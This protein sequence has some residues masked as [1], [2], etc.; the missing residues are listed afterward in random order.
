MNR[1]RLL[2]ITQDTCNSHDSVEEKQNKTLTQAVVKVLRENNERIQRG[3]A[4]KPGKEGAREGPVC[5]L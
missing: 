3:K 5:L 1:S 2:E 4:E